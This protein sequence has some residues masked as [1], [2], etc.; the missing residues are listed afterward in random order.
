MERILLTS[1]RVGT[2]LAAGGAAVA[3]LT[4][5]VPHDDAFTIL[6]AVLAV[7]LLA[8]PVVGAAA[9]RAAPRNAVSWLL[10][11]AGTTLPVAIAAY[12]YARA[13]FDDGHH[14]PAAR[15]A[16]WLDGWPWVPAMLL[17]PTFGI[18][19]FPDGRL[20]SPRWRVA[21]VL[22]LLLACSLFFGLLFG[23]GLL[24]WADVDNPTGLP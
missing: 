11:A 18:L 22:D 8:V 24:D 23:S 13:A 12:G 19:L 6:M 21:W 2:A 17:V 14:L 7:A 20:P 5:A 1:G 3:V 9:V 4:A 15:L 10:L 16:G